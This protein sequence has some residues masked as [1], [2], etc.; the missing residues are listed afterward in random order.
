MRDGWRRVLLGDVAEVVGGS[1]PRTSTP[2]YW[3]GGIP[4][5]T[6]GEV[7]RQEGRTIYST[8]RT[9]TNAGLAAVRGR[10][11]PIDSILLT[12]RATVGAA[13]LAGVPMA[14]NQGFAALIAGPDVD[15]HW[16][17]YWSQAH[18]REFE[19]LAGGST[20]PEISKPKVRTVALDLPPLAEQRR[21]VDLARG[22]DRAVEAAKQEVRALS[23]LRRIAIM[24]AVASISDRAVPLSEVLE[25]VIGGAWGSPA[26]AEEVDADA[27]N[28]LVFNN[29]Y[30]AVDPT[31]STRRSFARARLN[32]RA[33]RVEDILLERSG[34]TND[35]AVGRVIY[36]AEAFPEAVPTDF[37]RLLRVDREVAEPRFVFWWLWARYQRGDTIPYQSK[38]TN[39]RNLRVNDYLALPIIVP[40]R[41][42]QRRVIRLGESLTDAI[43]AAKRVVLQYLTVRRV[44]LGEIFAGRREIPSSYDRFVDGAA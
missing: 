34:G 40:S 19:A 23:E 38:T 27:L 24:E 18:R 15:P 21:L 22:L 29:E 9:L 1:T 8:D 31:H 39:I 26:G 7:T 5:I 41:D 42:E 13:A 17:L 11:L 3:G 43:G 44:L 14:V 2:T 32:G 10:L 12:S 28:L 36:A 20:F 16:L 25:L 35:R 37:M 6:P 4:W 30:L 33:L